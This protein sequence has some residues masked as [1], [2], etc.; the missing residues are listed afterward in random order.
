MLTSRRA[1]NTAPEHANE[2]SWSHGA[3]QLAQVQAMAI[4][5]SCRLFLVYQ[6]SS[7]AALLASMP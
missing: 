5:L 1:Y 7:S 6:Q 3:C 4:W 2:S